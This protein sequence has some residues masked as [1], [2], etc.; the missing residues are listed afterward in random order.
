MLMPTRS[1]QNGKTSSSHGIDGLA[2]S[3]RRPAAQPTTATT[4]LWIRKRKAMV[5]DVIMKTAPIRTH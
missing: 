4:R 2:K 5:D 1:T 3:S